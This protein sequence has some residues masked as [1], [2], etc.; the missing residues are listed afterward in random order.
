[1]PYIVRDIMTSPVV[2]VEQDDTVAHALTTMRRLNIHSVVVAPPA[3]SSTPR[4][5][6][7]PYLPSSQW[8]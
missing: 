6:S 4:W 3:A 1:M 5:S 8:R 7:S 2:I